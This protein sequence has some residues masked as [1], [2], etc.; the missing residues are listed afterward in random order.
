M[1]L[2]ARFSVAGP[3]PFLLAA[4]FFPGHPYIPYASKKLLPTVEFVPTRICTLYFSVTYILY[5]FVPSSLGSNVIGDEG[6]MAVA[7]G[8]RN[9]PNL[10]HLKYVCI[11][12]LFLLKFGRNQQAKV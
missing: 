11:Y 5:V 4:I 7:E 12:T 10:Y 8:L 2:H 3:I 1:L 6:A 9:Y